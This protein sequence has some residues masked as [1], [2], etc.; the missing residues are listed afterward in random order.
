MVTD[1][2]G[3]TLLASF[4]PSPR[5]NVAGAATDPC[6]ATACTNRA[7]SA[8]PIAT[9]VRVDAADAPIVDQTYD[10]LFVINGVDAP[11]RGRTLR[12]IF[13]GDVPTFLES[14]TGSVV[15]RTFGNGKTC[16][17]WPSFGDA[18][19]NNS[20]VVL[21]DPSACDG[22]VFSIGVGASYNE[23]QGNCDG[24]PQDPKTTFPQAYRFW[25]R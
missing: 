25:S 12:E 24:W 13:E 18:V 10:L 20:L 2:G 19:C 9:D 15:V 21:R 8:L 11:T 14:R 1:G 3:W 22:T 4:G 6:F 5:F 17:S 23:V 7:Y 16:D